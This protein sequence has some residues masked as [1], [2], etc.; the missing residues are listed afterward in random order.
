MAEDASVNDRLFF[1]LWPDPDVQARL[2]SLAAA[3]EGRRVATENLHLTLAFLGLT[4]TDR[5]ACYERA[6]QTV[7]FVPFDLVLTEVQWQ[8]RRGIAWM[9]ARGVPAEL[10]AL[11][12]ALNDALRKCGFTPEARP[13]R[14]HVTLARKVR[15]GGRV[16][17]DPIR[18]RVDRFWLVSSQLAPGGSRYTPE[19]CWPT[20]A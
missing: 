7:P 9:A 20:P 18:W 14:A 12:S 6:A 15:R 11:V 2:A 8:R 13:F 4:D 17:P 3:Y 10:T 16:E 5:R 1:A 19:R